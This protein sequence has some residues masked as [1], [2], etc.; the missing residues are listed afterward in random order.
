[1]VKECQVHLLRM[2]KIELERER[3]RERERE[4]GRYILE[5]NR[6]FIPPHLRNLEQGNRVPKLSLLIL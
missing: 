5:I 4:N 3:E 6:L 1:M 2:R